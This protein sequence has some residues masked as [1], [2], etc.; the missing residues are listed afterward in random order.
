MGTTFTFGVY[1]YEEHE[2]RA[3]GNE[4]NHG[5]TQEKTLNRHE[6]DHISARSS[7]HKVTRDPKSTRDDTKVAV[8]LCEEVLMVFF[9][10]RS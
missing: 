3:E 7:R 8:L 5:G 6:Y 10:W 1:P 4:G 9:E 2:E